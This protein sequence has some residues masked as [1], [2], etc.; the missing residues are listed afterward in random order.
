MKKMQPWTLDEYKEIIDFPTHIVAIISPEGTYKK[1]NDRMDLLGWKGEEIYG[2]NLNDFIHPGDRERTLGAMEKLFTGELA[3]VRDHA[4]RCLQKDGNYRWLS[5]SGKVKDGDLYCIGTDISEKVKF[6]EELIFQTLVLES[7]SEGVVICRE[8]GE[9][10]YVNHAEEKLFGYRSEELLGKKL[11]TLNGLSKEESKRKIEEVFKEL[12]ARGV[13]IGEW[14]N[15]KK[16][17]TLLTTS[18]QVTNLIIR[19]ERNVVIVQ[20]DVTDKKRKEAERDALQNRF[21][22]FF[23]QSILPMQIYGMDG[24]PLEVNQAWCDLFQTTRDELE[25]YNILTDSSTSNIGLLPYVKRAYAGEAVEAPAFYF[26]PKDLGRKG[27]ARWLEAWFSPVLD[28]DKKVKELAI[29]LKD[30]TLRKET[31]AKLKVSMSQKKLAEDNFKLVSDRLSM[32][33]K[34]GKIGIWEW[35]PGH[36]KV[37]WDETLESIYGYK[38]GTF[39]GEINDYTNSIHPED[40]EKLWETVAEAQKLKRPYILEHRIIRADGEIRWIHCSGTTFYDEAGTPILMMGTAMDITDKKISALDQKFLSEVSEILSS[41]FNFLETLQTAAEYASEFFCDGCFIDQLTP[42]GEI[43][44]IV[45]SSHDESIKDRI[46]H[47]HQ[48]FPLR[49]DPDHPLF[50]SLFTGKTA[51]FENTM[52]MGPLLREKFG[53]EYLEEV[54]RINYQSTIVVRLKGRENLL[55]T[56]TFFTVKN[57]KHK[58]DSRHKYLAEELGYRTSMAIEN[59]LL[60]L[61]SQEAIKS[62][63]EFLSIASHELKTPLTSLFLQN[64]M[65]KRELDKGNSSLLEESNIRKMIDADER[66]L[67]R[68]NRLIDDMLDIARIRAQRLSIQKENFEF[69]SFV[70]DVIERFR[71]Q[72]EASGCDLSL[73]LA[74]PVYINADIYRL[75]QVVVNLLTNAM[76]YGAGRPVRIEVVTSSRKLTLK[77]H[78]NGPGISPVDLERIF[79]RFERAVHGREI[80]G[81]GL[82]LYISR[83]IVEEHEGAL[84][85]TS[86]PGKGATFIMDLPLSQ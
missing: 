15:R 25:G 68:I 73:I 20:R 48:K 66:Q 11:A 4:V 75:E 28:D 59:S 55:G 51:Y 63:D 29:V 79:L 80:S 35:R 5:W 30:V 21:R 31:E 1:V 22:T 13:W 39:T 70:S 77:I 61:N 14:E 86:A 50:K 8:E 42:E 85:A 37:F 82:G 18:C 2:E 33:V 47:L 3:L 54:S 57:G 45:V 7:I 69:C 81:L 49:H 23:E 17:G 64:Q 34:V 84:F 46:I 32:A 16:D 40:R 67:K 78:D 9:I 19:G 62:R 53:D 83:K 12:D 41:S 24:F 26:D 71:A 27:R 56:M 44:R 65:R 52:E 60:F 74:D 36:N 10:L 6:E 72:M 38:P 43:K 58:F 76:K